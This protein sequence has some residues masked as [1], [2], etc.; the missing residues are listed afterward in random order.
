M[1]FKIKKWII[2]IFVMIFV[3]HGIMVG[4]IMQEMQTVS[5]AKPKLPLPTYEIHQLEGLCAKYVIFKSPKED[6][7]VYINYAASYNYDDEYVEIA[8]TMFFYYS[9]SVY[10]YAYGENYEPSDIQLL[11][12]DIECSEELP[13]GMTITHLSFEDWNTE[14]LIY[15]KYYDF[16]QN[17]NLGDSILQIPADSLTFRKCGDWEM[18][19]YG[20]RMLVQPITISDQLGDEYGPP[21]YMYMVTGAT[22]YALSF[23]E[24]KNE[25]DPANACLCS[26]RAFSGPFDLVLYMCGQYS[27]ENEESV[28]VFLSSDNKTWTLHDKIGTNS[29]KTLDQVMTRYNGVDSVYILIKSVSDDYKSKTLIFDLF[30]NYGFIAYPIGVRPGADEID[31]VISDRFR[32]PKRDTFYDLFGRPIK[33][34]KRAVGIK[35]TEYGDGSRKIEKIIGK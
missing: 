10:F 26:T 7:Q 5:L 29:Y 17:V 20:Q 1:D 28:E 23:M 22:N 8:D 31:I 16:Y 24:R 32:F 15:D 11:N 19:S 33:D 30:V 21:M 3:S 35:V 27:E 25:E 13:E 18:R 2:T 14:E 6:A 9:E 4:N 34:F 12:I